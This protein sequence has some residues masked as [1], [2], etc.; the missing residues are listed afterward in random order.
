MLYFG[1]PTAGVTLSLLSRGSLVRLP[2]KIGSLI[3]SPG[4]DPPFVTFISTTTV[5]AAVALRPLHEAID[6]SRE[7]PTIAWIPGRLSLH[8]IST[9]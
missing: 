3:A 1:L 8:I 5:P 9:E 6:R 2:G 7:L 4:E